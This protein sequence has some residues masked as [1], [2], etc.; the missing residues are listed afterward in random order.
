[1]KNTNMILNKVPKLGAIMPYYLKNL[2]LNDHAQACILS[3]SPKNAKAY[4]TLFVVHD[5][6]H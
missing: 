6:C 2:S 4:N 1:M 3:N 5:E